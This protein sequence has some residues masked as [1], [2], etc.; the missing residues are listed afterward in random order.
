[1]LKGET[2]EIISDPRSVLCILAQLF[3]LCLI[4]GAFVL[5]DHK[6]LS[7]TLGP[8]VRI[9]NYPRF[10]LRYYTVSTVH[11]LCSQQ[12]V[13]QHSVLKYMKISVVKHVYIYTSWSK[14][15][16]ASCQSRLRIC[17]QMSSGEVR[18]CCQMCYKNSVRRALWILKMQAS[19]SGSTVL[20]HGWPLLLFTLISHLQWTQ[21]KA[22]EESILGSVGKAQRKAECLALQ[23]PSTPFG[24]DNRELREPRKWIRTGVQETKIPTACLGAVPSRTASHPQKLP[25]KVSQHW[26]SAR[27]SN[28]GKVIQYWRSIHVCQ[29]RGWLYLNLGRE[30]QETVSNI[31]PQVNYLQTLSSN[32]YIDMLNS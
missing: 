8:N 4:S 21:N 28:L 19:V 11:Y 24:P 26:L 6:A 12:V 14:S 23:L 25:P 18:F 32:T 16:I 29:L 5:Q 31:E 30:L 13:R 15:A 27:R 17:F 9:Q 2:S 1:M 22:R 10:L 7:K 20:F 3:T